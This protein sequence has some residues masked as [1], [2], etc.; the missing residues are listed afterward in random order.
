MVDNAPIAVFDFVLLAIAT[1]AIA[2]YWTNSGIGKPIHG[3]IARWLKRKGWPERDVPPLEAMAKAVTETAEFLSEVITA[4]PSER[5]PV[6]V[7]FSQSVY[8]FIHKGWTCALCSGQ[9]VAFIDYSL[10]TEKLPT[11][12][13]RYDLVTMVAIN[14]VGVITVQARDIMI[15][16][17]DLFPLRICQDG[18]GGFKVCTPEG[19]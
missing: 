12:W 19:K 15:S 10:W 5:K 17:M 9:W 3:P 6:K 14:G 7:P 4:K 1:R 16:L 8:R 18:E 2:W 11:Q 13:D